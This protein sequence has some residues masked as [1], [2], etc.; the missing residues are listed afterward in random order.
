MSDLTSLQTLDLADNQIT[1]VSDLSD[2]TALK[3]LDLRNNDVGNVTPLSTMTRLTHLYLAGND[4]LS[5]LKQLLKLTRTTI[6]I[7]LPELVVFA[8][9][10]VEFAVSIALGFSFGDL[11]TGEDMETLTT[12]SV[13]FSTAT[14][15]TGLEAATNLTSLRLVNNNIVNLDPLSGLEK[16]ETLQLANNQVVNLRPLS[17]L[18]NL[19][20][21]DLSHNAIVKL[22]DLS[23]LSTLTELDLS[24][25]AITDVSPL[26][27]L[28]NLNQLDLTGNTG[29]TNPG[30]LYKLKQNGT[31]I[32]GVDVPDVVVFENTNLE[33]AVKQALKIPTTNAIL[34]DVIT[35]LTRLTATHK[36]I[37]DLTGLQ[38]ATALTRLDLGNNEI[39]D[40][41]PLQNLTSLTNLDLADNEIA[42][43]PSLQNLTNLTHLDL[44]DNE[45]QD[46]SGLSNL[47]NLTNLDL[48]GN[49]VGDV[50]PLRDLTRL[51]Y[52]YLSG[53]EN[54]TNL[55]WLGALENLRVDIRLPDVV[56]LPDINLDT[57]VRNALRN[58]GNTVSNDLPMSEELLESLQTLSASNRNIADLTGSEHMTGLTLLDL[59]DNEINDVSPLSRLYSLETLRLDGNPILDTSVLRE[60]ERRG[61][62][63]DITIYRYPSWDV[64]QDGRVD[65]TD[66]F[67][68]TATLTNESPDVNGD[69]V[70]DAD[71]REAADA[72]KDGTVDTDDLL[73]V[74]EK[75][76]RPVKLAAPLRN[77]DFDWELL[78]RIDTHQLRR[79]LDVLRAEN[80]GTL[81]YQKAINFLQAVLIALQP[82]QTLLLAN[83][84]NPFNPETWIPYQLARSAEVWI[85]IYDTQG[86]LVRRL[87]L[88]YCPE[89]YY[90]VRGRA[91]HWDGRNQIGEK[92]ASGVY[93]YQLNTKDISLLRKM[94]ILK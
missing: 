12:L 80:D 30:V 42:N 44:D 43:L 4:N 69:G 9:R 77:T 58:A 60:L 57:A 54:L 10:A 39:A 51:R 8:E 36:Q 24:N 17:G 85:T 48:R 81:K 29:I 34:P 26:S 33:N 84:P 79:H 45:I 75:F 13:T 82:N 78:E 21:L 68:I 49:D 41:V 3:R 5:H 92:V 65:E 76:D 87:E 46:V 62:D 90:R 72:N 2:L 1:N 70:V 52:I 89:G 7:D 53:N 22:N 88:G 59:R 28:T 37:D 61:T 15:L 38:R 23:G 86:V 6:D 18:S 93:F 14:N 83:Y 40:L 20:E 66:V 50:A 27:E 32:T 31:T 71:D 73:L 91:A 35:T 19:R 47:T 94:V 67:L 56:R 74:F 11:I 16:L 55:E 25:N 64:N 63:I